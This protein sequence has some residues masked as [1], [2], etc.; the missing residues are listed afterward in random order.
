LG[1]KSVKDVKASLPGMSNPLYDLNATNAITSF[2]R[3]IC[4][5][6]SSAEFKQLNE[7]RDVMAAHPNMVKPLSHEGTTAVCVPRPEA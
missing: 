4:E 3:L 1:R 2:P 6:I 7:T 5:A